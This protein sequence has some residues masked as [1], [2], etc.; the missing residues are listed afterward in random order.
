[1]GVSRESMYYIYHGISN[2]IAERAGLR[3]W[4]HRSNSGSFNER[5]CEPGQTYLVCL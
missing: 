1:M 2:D 4:R 3:T 5:V